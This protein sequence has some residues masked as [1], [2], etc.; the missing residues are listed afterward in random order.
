MKELFY[1]L[2]GTEKDATDFL[3]EHVESV[4]GEQSKFWVAEDLPAKEAEEVWGSEV[5][6]PNHRVFLIHADVT[7]HDFE[8]MELWQEWLER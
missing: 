2:H 3:K 5:E 7:E 8:T 4:E 1:F 6:D